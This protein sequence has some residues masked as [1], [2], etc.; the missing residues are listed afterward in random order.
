VQWLTA[1]RGIVHSE[2]F[3]LLETGGP[4]PAELFQIWLNLP[5][6]DK[7]APPHFSMLWAETIPAVR[8][9]DPGRPQAEVRVVAG[10][11]GGARPPPPPPH[12][13]ASR[14]AA[15]VA[16]FTIKL[17]EGATWT[18]PPAAGPETN[19]TLYFFLGPVLELAGRRLREH[20]GLRLRGEL[21][22][23]IGAPEGPVEAL[24]LQG[25]PIGEPVAQHGPFVMNTRQELQQAFW[26]YQQTRFGG[27]PWPD[28]G[29]VHGGERR[30]FARGPNGERDEPGG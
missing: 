1:G 14:K 9:G 7:M 25:R 21:P 16:I 3:P 28:D 17:E 24:L 6:S 18:L 20:A 30:R 10:D 12:S 23:E 11:L 26:D 27:W 4:N 13:W 29:P 8:H 2:M 19:R 22:V 15:D 5:A